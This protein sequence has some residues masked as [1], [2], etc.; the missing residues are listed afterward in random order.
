M[1]VGDQWRGAE[2]LEVAGTEIYVDLK[3]LFAQIDT[4]SGS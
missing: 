1:C 2:R 3:Q 4:P